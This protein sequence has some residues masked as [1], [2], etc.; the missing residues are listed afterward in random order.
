MIGSAGFNGQPV[1]GKVEI[2]YG[3]FERFRQ[4]GLGTE[5]CQLMVE[6]SIKTD[7]SVVI[8][9]RT[10]PDKNYSTRILEKNSF[11]LLGTVIEKEDGEVWEWEYKKG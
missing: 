6:L 1:V 7:P 10:L 4:K 2:A 5:I 11:E 8:T 9:A 3:T